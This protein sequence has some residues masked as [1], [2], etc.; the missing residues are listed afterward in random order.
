[1]T[2]LEKYNKLVK[3]NLHVNDEDLNDDVLVYNRIRGW[4][5]VSHMG[6]VA[7]L[8]EKFC[9]AFETLDIMSF[10]TYSAGIGILRNLGVDMDK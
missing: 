6:L 2:N 4:N 1:M 10:N 7:D 5:S 8:E 9:V 3:L